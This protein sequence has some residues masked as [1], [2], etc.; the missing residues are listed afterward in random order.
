MEEGSRT[1]EVDFFWIAERKW[2]HRKDE[3][4]KPDKASLSM[5]D[6]VR[7]RGR[8]KETRIRKQ[9]KSSTR[10]SARYWVQSAR[11]ASG[12]KIDINRVC[13][14]GRRKQWQLSHKLTHCTVPK[15]LILSFYLPGA[16]RLPSCCNHK[17]YK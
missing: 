5:E 12:G 4:A 9:K 6:G 16:H 14:D 11:E 17:D 15:S 13:I 2:T 3:W 7:K 10:P 1:R 8:P